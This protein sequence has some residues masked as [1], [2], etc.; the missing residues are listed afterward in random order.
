MRHPDLAPFER[1]VDI[2]S[3]TSRNLLAVSDELAG[4]VERAASAIVSVHADQ[5]SP[6]SGVVW[7]DGVVV[8]AAHTIKREEDIAITFPDGNRG[9]ASLAGFDAGTDLAVLKGETARSTAMEKSAAGSLRVGQLA[10]AVARVS[11]HSVNAALGMIGGLGGA[12]RTWRGGKVEQLIR[13]AITLYPGFSGGALL[14]ARGT[15]IGVNTAGLARSGGIALPHSTVDRVADELLARGYIARPYLGLA[16]QSVRLPESLRAKLHL[17]REAGVIVLG[18]EAA[19]PAERAGV[20]VGD[21]L[22]NVNGQPVSDTV[23]LQQALAG[24]IGH[25]ASATVVRG[26][27]LVALEAT[28]GERPHRSR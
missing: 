27:E 26:G 1:G 16:A 3:Q 28:P 13:V 10:I 7:R 21:I 18:L 25:T 15:V 12:W 11:E 5:R 19:G 23:D 6:S 9:R 20:L 17:E 14:D 22:V 2:M 8:T 24:L 4:V